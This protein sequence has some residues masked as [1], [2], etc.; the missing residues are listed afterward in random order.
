MINFVKASAAARSGPAVVEPHS[1]I[2]AVG[3]LH[4]A[5]AGQQPSGMAVRQFSDALFDSNRDLMEF[6]MN[7]AVVCR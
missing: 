5:G 6:S 3:A 4:H 2:L 1:Y 7:F